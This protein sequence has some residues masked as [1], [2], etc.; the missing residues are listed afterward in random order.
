VLFTSCEMVYKL[1]TVSQPS[2]ISVEAFEMLV[3]KLLSGQFI[4]VQ[5]M[6][7]EWKLR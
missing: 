7:F 5:K 4:D 1:C 6:L 2:A 3:L